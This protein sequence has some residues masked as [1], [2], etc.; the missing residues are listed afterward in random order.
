MSRLNALSEDVAQALRDMRETALEYHG[1]EASV[2]VEVRLG[3]FL[4][5]STGLRFDYGKELYVLPS[6]KG[7]IQGDAAFDA[8]VS[9]E[10]HARV[11]AALQ[12]AA[13]LGRLTCE[14]TAEEVYI[15]DTVER[16]TS[17]RLFVEGA[18]QKPLAMQRKQTL[19][20]VDACI[21]MP[22]PHSVRAHPCFPLP[23]RATR[24]NALRHGLRRYAMP[25]S[26]YRSRLNCLPLS[27]PRQSRLAGVGV[28][29]VT[30]I[31]IPF[32]GHPAP[33]Q[34]AGGWI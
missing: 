17:Q 12:R 28:A 14:H 34:Q 6:S 25:E 27:C 11:H 32:R 26:A 9:K 15:Y 1:G 5:K 29:N 3:R 7:A 33:P 13:T 2:E 10:H 21:F 30:A 31:P 4:S 22:P 23:H 24:G 19:R 20:D 8:G 16:G 18:S